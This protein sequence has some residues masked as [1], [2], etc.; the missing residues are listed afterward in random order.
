MKIA[1]LGYGSQG[2]SAYQYWNNSS[3]QITVCDSRENIQLPDGCNSKLGKDYLNDLDQFD[4]I[5]R[6]APIIHPKDIIKANP[7]NPDI[8]NKVTSNTNEFFRVSPTKNIIGVT[9]TKGKGTTST[10]IANMLEKAGF[11]V[12]LGG[13]IGVPPLELLNNNIQEND[14]V[15]L[16]LANFQLIDV[17]YSPKIAVCLM[18]VPEHM[19][20]HEDL[21]EYIAAKQQLF[22]NQSEDDVA[23]YY[24]DNENSESIASASEGKLIPYFEKPGA[25]VANNKI[26]I[27]NSDVCDVSD[28]ALLGKHN[29]QNV[30]AAV[31]AVWQITNN[32]EAMSEVIK[33]FNGMEHRLELVREIN[34]VKYYDDSF[35][36]TPETA[37]VAIEAFAE[38]KIVILGGSDKGA[39]FDELA[40]VVK[41][42]NVKQVLLIGQMAEMI[43]KSLDKV[44]YSDYIDGG[45]SMEEI[46]AN[47]IKIATKGDVVLLSTGCASFGMFEN[48]K[49]RG[50]Q[51]KTAVKSLA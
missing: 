43:K 17:K 34:G 44:G 1:I 29:W 51:F 16:E 27:D 21:E 14:W 37:I 13:N 18:V 2:I 11:N 36:T 23:I 28:I 4:I 38:P 47:A 42:N 20:W 7:G 33:N 9:G 6:A 5:V 22:I 50:E 35:G 3:N 49:D 31:T 46:V 25:I 45:K 15:V 32:I 19:D 24:T 39:H 30:C 12:H 10:L 41:N 48:Y 40:K 26:I 8:L